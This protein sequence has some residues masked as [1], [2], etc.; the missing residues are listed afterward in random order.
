MSLTQTNHPQTRSL[1]PTFNPPALL[2]IV[3]EIPAMPEDA[4]KEPEDADCRLHNAYSRSFPAQKNSVVFAQLSSFS[5][6]LFFFSFSFFFLHLDFHSAFFSFFLFSP[7]LCFPLLFSFLPFLGGEEFLNNG[8]K[9]R[10]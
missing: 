9:S 8:L 6:A 4:G 5:F 1:N 2:L 7:F 10:A 3:A